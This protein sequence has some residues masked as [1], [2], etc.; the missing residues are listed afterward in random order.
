MA[1]LEPK[2][3]ITELRMQKL[4]LVMDEK[5]KRELANWKRSQFK[6]LN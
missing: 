4:H 3:K 1:I 6:Y 5:Q 2:N